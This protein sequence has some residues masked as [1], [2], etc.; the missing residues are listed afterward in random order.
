MMLKEL[1][2]DGGS[3]L[4]LLFDRLAV[5]PHNRTTAQSSKLKAQSSKLKA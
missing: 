3:F 5:Q 4:L 2:F 1:P